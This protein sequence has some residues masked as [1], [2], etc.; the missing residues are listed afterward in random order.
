M[1]A[2]SSSAGSSGKRRCRGGRTGNFSSTAIRRKRASASAI[3]AWPAT[4]SRSEG[5]M[6]RVLETRSFSPKR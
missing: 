4:V 2:T 1:T 5:C 6:A 3:R